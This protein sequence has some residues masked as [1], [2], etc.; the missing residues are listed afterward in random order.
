MFICDQCL[1]QGYRREDIF[2]MFRSYGRCEDCNKIK[3]CHDI[4][5]NILFWHM[6]QE[7]N[8]VNPFGN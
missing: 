3:E 2:T 4:P 1:E 6:R 8:N 5:T 7:P